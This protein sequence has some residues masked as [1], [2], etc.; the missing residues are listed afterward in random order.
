MQS[1]LFYLTQA[2][3]KIK[4]ILP[5]TNLSISVCKFDLVQVLASMSVVS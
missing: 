4:Y 1:L 5:E 2:T 3:V